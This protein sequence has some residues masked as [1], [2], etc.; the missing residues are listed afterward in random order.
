MSELTENIDKLHTTKMGLDR[1][2]KN[3]LLETDDAVLWCK[4]KI[5]DKDTVIKRIGKNYYAETDDIKIT[6]NAHSFTIITAHKI[7]L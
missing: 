4:M 1:I 7:R 5:L 6:V 2:K 3:L